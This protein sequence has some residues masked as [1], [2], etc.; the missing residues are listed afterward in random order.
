MSTPID[1]AL[2]VTA[3]N[4]ESDSPLAKEEV[5]RKIKLLE[6]DLTQV[7]GLACIL[8]GNLDSLDFIKGDFG[9]LKTGM[10]ILQG[11]V[12]Q[13]E[14]DL[15][16]VSVSLSRLSQDLEL[17]NMQVGD[18]ENRFTPDRIRQL[19][20]ET[21][22]SRIDIINGRIDERSRKARENLDE[23]LCWIEDETTRYMKAQTTLPIGG[24][25]ALQ[26][27]VEQFR[28][29][30]AGFEKRW[31]ESQ[32]DN[33][34]LKVKLIE[35]EHQIEN[36]KSD[37]LRLSVEELVRRQKELNESRAKLEMFE[38]LEAEK[39]ALTEALR[40]YQS[41][42]L[43]FVAQ[44]RD[45][46]EFQELLARKD[47]LDRNLA[48][49]TAERNRACNGRDQFKKSFERVNA[50]L[51]KKS[52]ELAVLES[53][54]EELTQLKSDKAL[55]QGYLKEAHRTADD[56]LL[57]H[58]AEKAK[59]E[60][61]QGALEQ[62]KEQ[63]AQADRRAAEAFHHKLR[64][65]IE[66]VQAQLR[67][68]H[69]IALKRETVA[70]ETRASDL[71]EKV[72]L[73][74]QQLG[75]AQQ[76]LKGLEESFVLRTREHEEKLRRE[77]QLRLQEV[78]AERTLLSSQNTELRLAVASLGIERHA[79]NQEMAEKV[80]QKAAI[81]V[82]LAELA[83]RRGELEV[84][85]KGLEDSLFNLRTKVLPR[86]QKLADLYNPIVL[87]RSH[88]HDDEEMGWLEGIAAGI[89]AADFNF[90]DRLLHSFHTSLKCADIS[91]IT[92][93]A[94]ISG[95]GKS[96]LPR[97]YADLGGINFVN[98]AVQPNWDSP[99]DLFG[100]FNYTEGR[101]KSTPLSRLLYQVS[102]KSAHNLKDQVV[103]VLLDE[104]NIAT[105]EYY[106][107]ELLSKLETRRGLTAGLN[108]W[109]RA[110][111][112]IDEGSLS[113]Q[114]ELALFL[115]H[116][117][118]FVGTMNEDESTRSLSDKVKDRAQMI[119][120]PSPNSFHE[121]RG[122]Q[123]VSP[124]EWYLPRASWESWLSRDSFSD[125]ARLKRISD[126]AE[127]FNRALRRVDRAIG[128]RVFQAMTRYILNYPVV[129]SEDKTY[130]F[131][132]SDVYA[133]KLMPKLNGLEWGAEPVG[134]CLE[135]IATMLPEELA[136]AFNKARS[137]ESGYFT[138][139]GN[140]AVF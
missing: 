119:T 64:Q 118:H 100:F 131:A 37:E 21:V 24:V 53:L 76:E 20:S 102:G 42:D 25:I 92:V 78:E 38:Q 129:A 43:E 26:A 2:A 59:T 56:Y 75:Q 67:L 81:V 91:P 74:Y 69:D 111:I 44:Q 135:E 63:L 114:E 88:S 60:Q 34:R 40:A 105:V 90:S 6:R 62:A 108:G 138:W 32:E 110:T 3:W 39:A 41:K 89:K 79:I 136:E 86:E 61:L 106:F 51:L 9:N 28:N 140:G 47:E 124:T 97:L 94:G 127:H 55:L 7:K 107:S 36:L 72:R 1:N 116:N 58:A 137:H 117:V 16:E 82:E 22:E 77:T 4:E 52:E 85:I 57:K 132:R 123:T 95:T 27:E 10:P 29:I 66:T 5:F 31:Q 68:E 12:S 23:I 35:F 48:T 128:H 112:R 46:A 30:A 134:I 8:A 45:L 99:E 120:F 18:V 130:E 98:I 14:A 33:A 115:D 13:V 122:G 49:M 54:Q 93:L 133:Q 71:Q 126:D 17:V 101:Y 83:G 139:Q 104:M 96:E 11:K 73:L 84:Q 125:Q 80:Q 103:I 70:A 109:K 50:E 65:E 113:D 121:R 15:S 87:A 19:A